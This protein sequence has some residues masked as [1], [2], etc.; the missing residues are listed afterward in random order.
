M[1]NYKTYL[2]IGVLLVLPYFYMQTRDRFIQFE[3]RVKRSLSLPPPK[4]ED[5]PKK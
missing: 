1:N 3:N 5:D 4:E 2:Q